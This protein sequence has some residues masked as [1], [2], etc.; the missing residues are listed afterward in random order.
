LKSKFNQFHVSLYIFK[1]F[2]SLTW[3]RFWRFSKILFHL[4]VTSIMCVIRSIIFFEPCAPC[5]Y[6][7]WTSKLHFIPNFHAFSKLFGFHYLLTILFLC[8]T[9]RYWNIPCKHWNIHCKLNYHVGCLWRKKFMN[10]KFCMKSTQWSFTR[11]CYMNFT[12]TKWNFNDGV[13]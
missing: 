7:L 4:C 1:N 9:Y 2:S 6:I 8:F 12:Q 5:A 13:L 11:N 3:M 10:M